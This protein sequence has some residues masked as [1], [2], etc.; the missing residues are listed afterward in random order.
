MVTKEILEL[1]TSLEEAIHT[2]HVLTTLEEFSERRAKD[3]NQ[4][5][6]TCEHFIK[7]CDYYSYLVE[8]PNERDIIY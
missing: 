1:S 6:A 4:L 5:K 7:A 8:H 3:F 2:I